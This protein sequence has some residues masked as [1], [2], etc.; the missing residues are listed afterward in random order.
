M[1]VGRFTNGS[2]AWLMSMRSNVCILSMVLALRFTRRAKATS[3]S[4]TPCDSRNVLSVLRASGS[5]SSGT[6]FWIL[7]GTAM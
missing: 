3:P 2:T 6:I 1:T 7:C 5:R 4:S